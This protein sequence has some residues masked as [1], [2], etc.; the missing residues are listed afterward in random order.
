MLLRCAGLIG[1]LS[2]LAGFSIL[3]GEALPNPRDLPAPPALECSRIKDFADNPDNYLFIDARRPDEYS[4]AHVPGAVN[5]PYDEVLGY[6]SLLPGY[7]G[8]PIVAYCRSGRRATILRD[9]LAD[10]G[11]FSIEVVPGEQM[12]SVDGRMIFTCDE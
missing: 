3:A 11:Y 1:L 8:Q 12:Y 5:I 9:V 6:S 2:L 10:L 4:V 7:P